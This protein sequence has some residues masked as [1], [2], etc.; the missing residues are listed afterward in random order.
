M[1]GD[2]SLRIIRS[3]LRPPQ[4]SDHVVARPRIEHRLRN[5]IE[6]HAV[7]IVS[8][9]AGAGKTT[10]V[11]RAL[12][13]DGRL[14]W[15]TVDDGDVAS[16]RLLTYVEASLAER[17]PEAMGVATAALRRRVGHA[18]AAGLLADSTDGHPVV[19]VIDEVERLIEAPGA[20]TVLN[21]LL[22]YVPT[23]MRIV[24]L[25][26]RDVPLELTGRGLPDAVAVVGETDLAFTADEAKE[27]LARVA[28][29]PVDAADAVAATG[30]WV[31]GVL[32]ESWRSADHVAGIGGEADPLHGYLATQILDRLD[33]PERELLIRTSPLRRV[34]PESAERLGV[35]DARRLLEGLRKHHLPV[36]WEPDGPALRCH[37]RFRE[38]LLE[39]LERRDDGT[40]QEI[41]RRDGGLLSE[42]GLF[43][44]A[45]E[46]Y[47]AADATEAALAAAD[48]AIGRV[49]ERL[50]LDVAERWIERLPPEALA[51]HPG[52]L[53]ATMMVA[54]GR[55]E[56][57]RGADAADELRDTADGRHVGRLSPQTMSMMAWCYWLVGRPEASREVVAEMP[58]GPERRAARYQLTAGDN[59]PTPERDDP[60]GAT[61]SPLDAQVM[62]V[63]YVTGRLRAVRDA[64]PTRWDAALTEPWRIEAERAM[65]QLD[66]AYRH[67]RS[68][69]EQ[70]MRSKRLEVIIGPE[71]LGDLGRVDEAL[72]AL[73]GARP[74]IVEAGCLI[75][76]LQSLLLEARLRLRFDLDRGHA[77]AVLES[78]A[79]R[80]ELAQY[81]FIREQVAACTGLALLHRGEDE[82][83]RSALRDAVDSMQAGR[84]ILDLPAAAVYLSEAAWRLGAEDE[85]DAAADLALDA[86]RRQGSKHLL[87]QALSDFPAVLAR[88]LDAEP[89]ADSRWHDLG[90]VLSAQPVEVGGPLAGSIRFHDFGAPQLVVN[91]EA[92]RAPI[93]K[94]LEVL[95]VL[96]DAPD[97]R[98]D[99]TEL[100]TALFDGRSDHSSRTYLRQA[101]H[102]L[103]ELMP[104]GV[105][106]ILDGE[107]AALEGATVVSDSARF[108]RMLDEAGRLGD[109]ERLN[110]LESALELY[111][112]GEYLAGR[113]S[114]WIEERRM[115]LADRAVDAR[116]DAAELSFAQGD[117]RT[118]Q[119][120]L[121]AVL[122]ADPYRES[123]WRLA[124]RV[125]AGYRDA[126]RAV[127][128]FR[129]CARTLAQVG[130]EPAPSTRQ[131]LQA[132]RR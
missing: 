41:R 108:E 112:S 92:V 57:R 84:R 45:T 126:D 17:A 93:T 30:G 107:Q 71:L 20:M 39:L 58:P 97:Y 3:K 68:A 47:L 82:A 90:R 109:A 11:A 2:E 81:A 1:T 42:W 105:G 4:P 19:L 38:Y 61:G 130:I 132:L 123:A 69:L 117:L 127:D 29:S 32:F 54:L 124:M 106:L 60:P 7:V 28:E 103:R 5:L 70:D 52:L 65:G 46:E 26:R 88:R 55:E 33:E 110:A 35:A 83:A 95:A 80:P 94:S 62:R 51:E 40:A 87:L 14:S 22:L 86:A 78:L 98:A 119:T 64:P 67:Y 27:A 89:D 31:T 118:A 34:E 18:D 114:M 9:T 59:E 66:T 129:R 99:R 101:V 111:A 15:L 85:A 91:G 25:S 49:V 36:A 131:L 122:A 125:A 77:L 63:N 116:F 113:D 10:A 102:R 44:E 16:G 72:S 128:V 23:S 96:A 53:T 56:F 12:D 13:G 120:H 8:A 104:E 79:A 48:Q 121:D 76:E 73:Q 74:R 24:L 100:L 6:R 115:R 75:W 37:P 43:E 50:D 21:A